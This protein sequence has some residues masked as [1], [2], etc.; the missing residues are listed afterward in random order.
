MGAFGQNWLTTMVGILNALLCLVV[1]Y[2][3]NGA[4]TST[5]ITA[6]ITNLTIGGASKSFNSYTKEADKKPEDRSI[7]QNLPKE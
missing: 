5:G 7:S 3:T 4:I 1:D 6:A 2:Q